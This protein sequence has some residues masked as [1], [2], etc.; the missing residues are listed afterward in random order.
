MSLVP[1]FLLLTLLTT[2]LFVPNLS[3]QT[4]KGT[5][6]IKK[7]SAV[8]LEYTLSDEKGKVI[9]SNKGEQ[10]LYYVHGRNEIVPGLEKALEGMAVGGVKHLTVKPQD[11]YGTIDMAAFR[12][13][14]K[15][16]VPKEA[17]KAGTELVANNAEGQSMPVRVHEIKD[18]TVVIDMNHPMAG[19]TLVFD[20]KVLDVKSATAK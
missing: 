7:G 11:G 3:A 13:V 20:I 4:A 2:F 5:N 16:N 9:E 19:K 1:R 15:E 8:S 6:I 14:P 12:E 18:K 10:P 17:L